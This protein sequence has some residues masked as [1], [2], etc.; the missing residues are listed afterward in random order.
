VKLSLLFLSFFFVASLKD[1]NSFF[2][3][4]IVAFNSLI[5]LTY[6]SEQAFSVLF[7][8]SYLTADLGLAFVSLD[9]S[10]LE[11]AGLDIL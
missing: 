7:F 10:L 2:S 3:F 8:F 6:L 5:S 1:L 4:A 11:V 9:L